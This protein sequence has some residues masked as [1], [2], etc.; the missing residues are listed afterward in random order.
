MRAV[1]KKICYVFG[2]GEYFGDLPQPETGDCV[3]AADGGLQQLEMQGIAADLVVGDFDSL[4]EIP[5]RFNMVKLPT[6]KD[7]TDMFA[8]LQAGLSQGYRRFRIYGGTGGRFDHTFANI[9]CLAFL[10]AQGAAGFLVGRDTVTAAISNGGSIRFGSEARGML[11]AFALTDTACGV[12][13]EGLKY[14][15]D[16]A[17]LQSIYPK[18]TSNEFVGRPAKIS[19]REGALLIIYPKDVSAEIE[20]AGG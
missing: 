8:A 5:K 9:Q 16:N 19:V 2:A 3:I 12:F 1:E 6:E 4:P 17:T 20:L 7:D 10:S 18:G 15:L 11:S 14:S 13:E